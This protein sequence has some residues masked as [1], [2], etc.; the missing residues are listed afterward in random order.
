M[1]ERDFDFISR[2]MEQE[3]I[4]YFFTHTEGTHTMVLADA[5]GAHSTVSG[6]EQIPYAPPTERGKRMKASISEWETA[7]SVNTTR[8]Q[9]D[10]Y[11][12]LKP[13][14]SLLATEEPTAK[15][16]VHNV[17]GL[18]IYDYPYEYVGYDQ[19][20]ALVQIGSRTRLK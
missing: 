15:D 20:L 13:K 19:R 18:D 7:R 6:F 10:D 3:G 11:C 8:V 4:Y 17:G 14:A 2:L 1:A 5:L 12:Y 9:L 16:D